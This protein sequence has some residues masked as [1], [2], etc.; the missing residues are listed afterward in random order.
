[1]SRHGMDDMP[2]PDSLAPLSH[3]YPGWNSD[4]TSPE[5][6]VDEM[7]MTSDEEDGDD[8]SAMVE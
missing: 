5:E 8:R 2:S 7:V 3:G 4:D 1:M 6:G